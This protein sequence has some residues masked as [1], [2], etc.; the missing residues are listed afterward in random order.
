MRREN[1]ETRDRSGPEVAFIVM[2]ALA[3]ARLLW[4][5][6]GALPLATLSDL[7]QAPAEA[8]AVT[9]DRLCDE[10]MAELSASDATVRLTERGMREMCA[11]A[12]SET[13]A[14]RSAM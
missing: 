10:G 1:H 7:V 13:P 3:T 6:G 9:V 12:D 2:R 4:A 14:L 8:V 5:R 11:L